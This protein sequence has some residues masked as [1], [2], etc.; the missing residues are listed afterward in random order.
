MARQSLVCSHTTYNHTTRLQPT[1]S[2]PHS[3]PIDP[4]EGP[5]KPPNM[6]GRGRPKN[7]K[8]GSSQTRTAGRFGGKKED[9][10]PPHTADTPPEHD[11]DTCYEGDE[12]DHSSS[13]H[14]SDS[15]NGN[16]SSGSSGSVQYDGKSKR[17]RR[18]RRQ[19]RRNAEEKRGMRTLLDMWTSAPPCSM[20]APAPTDDNSKAGEVEDGAVV[21]EIEG[22]ED[23]GDELCNWFGEDDMLGIDVCFEGRSSA[24]EGLIFGG[25]GG[26]SANCTSSEESNMEWS[27]IE[28]TQQQPSEGALRNPESFTADGGSAAQRKSRRVQPAATAAPRPKRVLPTGRAVK[29]RHTHPYT[30]FYY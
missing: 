5:P 14:S 18:R 15:D 22:G 12:E 16:C 8:P 3:S 29:K 28:E 26:D 17:T 9:P 21:F 30:W 4:S 25:Y 19:M 10:T 6:T 27:D 11:D 20:P 23:D 2:T 1:Y 7:R 24:S 13:R